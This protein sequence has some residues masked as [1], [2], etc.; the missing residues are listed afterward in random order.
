[1]EG[2]L[3]DRE[4]R[5]GEGTRPSVSEEVGAPDGVT[6]KRRRIRTAFPVTTPFRDTGVTGPSGASS[7]IVTEG[8]PTTPL[9]QHQPGGREGAE[10]PLRV[11]KNRRVYGPRVVTKGGWYTHKELTKDDSRYPSLDK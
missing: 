7:C 2:S 10:D 3:P 5:G 4:D 11:R 8:G 1:M 9:S 6:A